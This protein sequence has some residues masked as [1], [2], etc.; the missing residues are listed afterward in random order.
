[1][2]PSKFGY[3][4]ERGQVSKDSSLYTR[5]HTM[6]CKLFERDTHESFYFSKKAHFWYLVGSFLLT[7]SAWVVNL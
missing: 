3:D 2:W 4:G 7:L 5:P 1:M 6:G